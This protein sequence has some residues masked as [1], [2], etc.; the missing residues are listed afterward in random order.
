[1]GMNQNPVPAPSADDPF[2]DVKTEMAK[3]YALLPEEIQKAIMSTDYQQKLFN[4]AKTHKL[5]YEELGTLEL[6]TTMVL[7][8]MTRPEEYRDEL[9][10]ELK[11]NDL[12]IDALVKDV[13]DQVFSPI[14]GALDRVYSAKKDPEDYLTQAPSSVPA[15]PVTKAPE[16]APVT[17]T[18]SAKPAQTTPPTFTPPAYSAP[19]PITPTPTPGTA[20]PFTATPLATKPVV[21]TPTPVVPTN[22]SV[23][24][25]PVR[26]PI[27]PAPV[28]PPTPAVAMPTPMAPVSDTLSAMEKSVL[29]KTGVV[30]SD[31][32]AVPVVEFQ[33]TITPKPATI[34]PLRTEMLHD[35]ENPAKSPTDSLTTAF[36]GMP[37]KTT[38]YSIPKTGTTPP[39]TRPAD[40]YREPIQ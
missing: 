33:S 6:E 2:A 37:T 8:G 5:T 39:T 9:Q 10:L 29:E 31:T 7:L 15:T 27:P 40:P 23:G 3:R 32:P 18:V 19:K 34:S 26:I 17:A 11:K 12:E 30:L 35:I 4:L 14:R 24:S 25:T 13:G 1:M 16:V 36:T 20:T 38:D 28:N 21:P 22:T